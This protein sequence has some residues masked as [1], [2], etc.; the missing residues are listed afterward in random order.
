MSPPSVAVIAVALVG[1]MMLTGRINWRFGAT[2]IIGCFILFGVGRDR[3][4]HPVDRCGLG[5]ADG[6]ARDPIFRALDPA[7]DVRG[8]D[9][10]TS[11]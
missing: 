3:V 10:S 11:S 5:L 9:L 6:A 8:G 1:F 2:V 7:A 4:G